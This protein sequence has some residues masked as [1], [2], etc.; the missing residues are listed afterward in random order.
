M[1]GLA[2]LIF[3]TPPVAARHVIEGPIGEIAEATE[4]VTRLDQEAA[5]PQTTPARREEVQTARAQQVE[6]ISRVAAANPRNDQ[7]NIAAA[8]S[9]LRVNEPARAELAAEQAV[10][11]A[12]QNPDTYLLRGRARMDRGNY[13]EAVGD[14][15]E[16]LRLRPNDRAAI[17][18]L[19]LSEGRGA[20]T[21]ENA[22]PPKASAFPTIR[23]TDPPKAESGFDDRV[24]TKA[25]RQKRAFEHYTAA[26]A[27]QS[28]RDWNR[29]VSE[30][31]KAVAL[32]P[33]DAFLKKHLASVIAAQEESRRPMVP[34]TEVNSQEEPSKLGAGSFL[35]G[36]AHYLGKT[37]KP[38]RVDFHELDTSGVRV[39]DFPA[40]AKAL[41][42]PQPGQSV[43]INSL[44]YWTTKGRQWLLL[45]DIGLILKGRL[46]FDEKCRW[47]FEG[48]LRSNDD[49]YDFNKGTRGL[50]GE[51]LTAFGRG[52]QGENYKVEIRGV[53]PV[54]ES[55]S[56]E[57]CP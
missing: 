53:K 54:K 25:E 2:L 37:A 7:V 8:D 35:G 56:K 22:S 18:F 49:R 6:Q 21:K 31:E 40:V 45:G 12:P 3:L 57:Y 13:E 43:S 38:R 36:F 19:K 51:S 16:V 4:A 48:S 1:S 47:S 29:A 46:T 24:G 15:R 26:Q 5:S 14:F 10:A 52:V 27:A 17:G 33:D 34:T 11:A 41:R 28:S 9:F 44:M 50:V 20:V 23:G 42:A 30:A 39:T 32:S 55:D